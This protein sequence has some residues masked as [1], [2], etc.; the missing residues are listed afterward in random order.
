MFQYRVDIIT[1]VE[2]SVV[3]TASSNVVSEKRK[4]DDS[5]YL[6]RFLLPF[7]ALVD[8]YPALISCLRTSS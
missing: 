5:D 2:C 4:L 8:V 6:G 7:H 3:K 1:I